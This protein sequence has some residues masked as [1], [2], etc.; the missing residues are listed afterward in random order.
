MSRVNITQDSLF[1]LTGEDST[2]PLGELRAL[3]NTYSNDAEIVKIGSRVVIVRGSIIPSRITERA[4]YTRI[5][6]I[7]LGLVSKNVNKDFR[8]LEFHKIPNFKTFA[9]R[10]YN[11][12][13]KNL[14]SDVAS[15]LGRVVKY[16]YPN[17][18]VSLNHPDII[19]A[20]VLIESGLYVFCVDNS[21]SPKSWYNRRPRIRPF[22]HP[23]VLY[24]K[25][26]RFLVNLTHVKEN[27]LL[28]DPFCG[29]G[30]ILIEA[31]LMGMHSFGG[32]ISRRMCIG[33]LKNLKYFNIQNSVVINCDMSRTPLLK[34]DGLSTD[35]PY[36][37]TSSTHN[38]KLEVISEELLDTISRILN[39]GKYASIVHPHFLKIPNDKRFEKIQEHSIYIHRSLTRI[40]TLLKRT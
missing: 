7:Y 24:P 28:L 1:V 16:Y 23:S 35:I 9:A 19:I 27:Q 12:T 17:L 18:K 30:S 15:E 31:S 11:L 38:K 33:A 14:Q 26:A 3:I 20:G 29:T 39:R 37:C 2:I 40:V 10:I 4:A 34:I 6:G 36:G 13:N 22:F 25:F 21:F 32:D 8:G 5:G